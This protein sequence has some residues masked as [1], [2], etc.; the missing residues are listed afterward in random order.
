M[1]EKVKEFTGDLGIDIVKSS[2]QKMHDSRKIRNDIIEFV[3]D[4]ELALLDDSC[5][6]EIDYQGYLNYIRENMLDEIKKYI[7]TVD[8]YEAESIKQTILA[9]ALSYE[10]NSHYSEGC[11]LFITKNCINIVKEYYK[12]KLDGENQLLA[13]ITVQTVLGTII[14]KIDTIGE[15]V[16]EI[17]KSLKDQEKKRQEDNAS[18]SKKVTEIADMLA[19]D[20]EKNKETFANTDTTGV[21][22][23]Y[24]KQDVPYAAELKEWFDCNSVIYDEYCYIDEYLVEEDSINYLGNKKNLIFLIGE[25]FLRNIHCVYGMLELVKDGSYTDCICP[26]VV[27]RSIFS[28]ANRTV[29]ISY[30][31]TKEIELR[32]TI[33]RLEKIQHA[34]NIVNEELVKYE[35][36]AQLIDELIVWLSKHSYSMSEVKEIIKKKLM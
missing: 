3:Q 11:I 17:K 1:I 9:E 19:N 29:R 26:V 14:P 36:T 18:I 24:C 5:Y 20:N 35:R 21:F 31:E 6:N 4:R 32:T 22:L 2:L 33:E 10:R 8:Y 13:H 25:A 7:C 23:V 27:E 15:N 28:T 34:R 30:W 12:G 16:E